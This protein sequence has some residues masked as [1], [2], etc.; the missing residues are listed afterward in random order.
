MCM[1]CTDH[2]QGRL[3]F[4]Q[5]VANLFEMRHDM[6]DSHVSE[7]LCLIGRDLEY[8]ISDRLDRMIMMIEDGV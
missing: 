1:I 5:L 3:T 8:P 7:V 6:E 4:D 2:S